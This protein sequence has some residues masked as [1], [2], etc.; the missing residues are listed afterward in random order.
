ASSRRPLHPSARRRLPGSG[1]ARRLLQRVRDDMGLRALLLCLVVGACAADERQFSSAA[2]RAYRGRCPG[3]SVD[4][5]FAPIDYPG[6]ALR[7][8]PGGG[9][10]GGGD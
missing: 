7:G 9:G 8:G 6:P 5:G 10:G 4:R 2:L 1:T 3:G